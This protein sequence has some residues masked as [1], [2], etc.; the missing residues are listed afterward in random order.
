VEIE[1]VSIANGTETDTRELAQV[2]LV[3][4]IQP[5]KGRLREWRL[6]RC[7][8]R[9]PQ[10]IVDEQFEGGRVDAIAVGVEYGSIELY[11]SLV[12][13][14]VVFKFV[15]SFPEFRKGVSSILTFVR[16]S[17]DRI[18]R[19]IERAEGSPVKLTVASIIAIV[20]FLK[21]APIGVGIGI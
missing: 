12:A 15:K 4:P 13:P 3:L 10:P 6:K 14:V 20:Q 8:E 9:Q 2:R 16:T 1:L 5:R 17:E 11:V 7:A 19:E 21:I 18:Q